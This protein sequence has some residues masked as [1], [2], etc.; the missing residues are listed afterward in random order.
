MA[1]TAIGEVS[2]W[3]GVADWSGCRT[4]EAV[5]EGGLRLHQTAT[6]DEREEWLTGGLMSVQPTSALRRRDWVQQQNG[7]DDSAEEDRAAPLRPGVS[8]GPLQSHKSYG[9]VGRRRVVP[10]LTGE[11][12]SACQGGRHRRRRASR[13]VCREQAAWWTLAR[14]YWSRGG[15]QGGE[16]FE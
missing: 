2:Q 9:G 5:T 14:V 11:L 16:P 12:N 15:D 6:T 4:V 13:R 3:G 8:S 1:Q 7:F 10:Q